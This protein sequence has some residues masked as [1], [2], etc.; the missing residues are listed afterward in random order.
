MWQGIHMK[1]PLDKDEFILTDESLLKMGQGIH[2][3]QWLGSTH[4]SVHS[5]NTFLEHK[6]LVSF[7]VIRI[8]V[9]YIVQ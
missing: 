8:A 3:T 7:M 2:K 4:S 5:E 9:M 6:H 1:G